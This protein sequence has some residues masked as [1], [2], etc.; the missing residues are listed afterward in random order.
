MFIDRLGRQR[1]DEVTE[2]LN[3]LTDKGLIIHTNIA[4]FVKQTAMELYC[5]RKREML[6]II[7]MK[8][9]MAC[10]FIVGKT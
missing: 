4:G 8:S 7:H 10:Q 6:P 3:S 9:V 1:M 5:L 2:A